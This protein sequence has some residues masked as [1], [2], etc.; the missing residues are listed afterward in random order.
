MPAITHVHY[1]AMR[2]YML[3]FMGVEWGLPLKF[4]TAIWSIKMALVIVIEDEQ[5]IREDIADDIR[6]AGHEVITAENGHIGI[7][8]ITVR[9]PDLV[10]CD[11]SM[12]EMTGYEVIV[13]LQKDHPALA[14]IPFIFISAHASSRAIK[15]GIGL[16]ASDY[17]TKPID[18]DKLIKSIDMHLEN[19]SALRSGDLANNTKVNTHQVSSR[20]NG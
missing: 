19:S 6:D 5:D 18:F 9:K 11:M 20:P 10:I 13:T 3:Q 4:N 17:I 15:D 2:V 8:L 7:K 12:K 14:N 1:L 16:G